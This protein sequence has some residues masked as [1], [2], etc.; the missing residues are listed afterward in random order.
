MCMS[1]VYF[2]EFPHFL[3]YAK[4]RLLWQIS[5]VLLK[6]RCLG[7]WFICTNL[8]KTSRNKVSAIA[9]AGFKINVKILIKT[10][11][12]IVFIV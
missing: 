2:F 4:I 8:D 7:H 12:R 6:G 10:T 3:N 9:V 1:I 11:N 5:N